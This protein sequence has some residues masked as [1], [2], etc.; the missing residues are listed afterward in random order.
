MHHST[1]CNPTLL[2][3]TTWIQFA[4]TWTP[5]AIVSG[6]A[7]YYCLGIAYGIGIMA[8]IDGVAIPIL[9]SSV[10]YA[11]IGAFMPTFQW[12]SAWAV[13]IVA[14]IAAGILYDLIERIV[15]AAYY[16]L[17]SDSNDDCQLTAVSIHRHR[18]RS[19]SSPASLTTI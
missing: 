7:G 1:S 6:L 15:R 12:Y 4:I 14:S 18:G 13:R 10:G 3:S 2:D 9:R 11:G 8:K 5:R 16:T 19:N 17:T